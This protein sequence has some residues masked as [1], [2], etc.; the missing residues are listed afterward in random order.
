MGTQTAERR[1][2]P[3]NLQDGLTHILPLAISA[4]DATSRAIPTVH[5]AGPAASLQ[6][7]LAVA[8]SMA[9]LA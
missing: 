8:R 2:T 5:E 7:M 9:L 6:S 3:R 1:K 4:M